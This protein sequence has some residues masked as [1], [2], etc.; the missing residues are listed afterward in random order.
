MLETKNRIMAL[1]NSGQL[2]E[3]RQVCLNACNSNTGSAELWFMLSAICGQMQD[4]LAA[5]QYCKKALKIN[6]SVPSV[7]YNLAV[8]QRGQGKTDEAFVSLEKAV[9]LQNDFTAAQYEMGNICLEKQDYARAIDFYN[10]VLKGASDAYQAYVGLAVA[11]ERSAKPELAISACLE[12][13]RINPAQQSVTLRLGS[14]YDKQGKAD[15]AVK[16]YSRAIELGY[17][18]VDVFINIGRMQALQGNSVEAENHYKQALT[19]DPDA[20]EALSNLALLYDDMHDIG[21]ALKYIK[22]AYQLD[23]EDE[24]I[25]YNYAKI[26]TSSR[27]YTDAETLYKKILEKNP[28][29]S[30]AAVNLGNLYLLAGKAN[31]AQEIYEHACNTRPDFHDACSNMLMSLNYTNSHSDT[32]IRDKHFA[33]ARLF[34]KDIKRLKKSFVN[35]DMKALKVGY[36]S[37]DFRN[38]SVAYFFEGVLKYSDAKKITNYCYSDVK[39]KD[40]VTQ[41]LEKY[42]DHWRDVAGLDNESLAHLIKQDDIDILIDLCGHISGNRLPV[43]ALKPAPVQITY[44]GYPNTTG[45]EAMDYRIVDRNTDPEGSEEMMSESPLYVEPSFLNYMPYQK[46]P[47]VAV[48]PALKNGYI[49]F[50]SFNNLAKMTDEV[51]GVWSKILSEISESRLCIKARQYSDS[52]IKQDHIK[53]FSDAGIDESR[54][55]LMGYSNT[56]TE[57]LQMYNTIDIALDTFPYNG[58]TTTFEALWMGVPVVCLNGTRHASRVGTSILKTLGLTE[59]LAEEKQQYVTI[60]C[61]LAKDVKKLSEIRSELRTKMTHSSLMDNE[62]FARKFESILLGVRRKN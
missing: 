34:E 56:T 2:Q 17:E 42:S 4:F 59:L 29:F 52:V 33:W 39:N 14:L 36:V 62:S 11:Y 51:I 27:Q 32:E 53:R 9:N 43:F 61:L 24:R 48:L 13:L 18:A 7:Y 57:H 60:S 45:L 8:A 28:D 26:L 10:K 38:H 25:V 30:E 21:S 12:S 46:S 22:E 31:E 49:T 58:T 5:E 23:A 44:L 6:S 35:N 20:I 55:D 40:E 41:R 50:G 15:E 47:D 19:I 3:A 54:L 16:Y 1:V 37:P